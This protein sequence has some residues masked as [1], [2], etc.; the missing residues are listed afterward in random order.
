[1]R[2]TMGIYEEEVYETWKR[3]YEGLSIAQGTNLYEASRDGY[4]TVSADGEK[5]GGVELDD[6]ERY[7]K[8]MGRPYK[9]GHQ[10]QLSGFSQN[11]R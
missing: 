10:I 6:Q 4:K 11:S 2:K 7:K 9:K 3:M 5:G 8:G 1:M